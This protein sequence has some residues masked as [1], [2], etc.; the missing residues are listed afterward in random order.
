[1]PRLRVAP[2]PPIPPSCRIRTFLHPHNPFQSPLPAQFHTSTPF[3]KW[4]DPRERLHLRTI[5]RKERREERMKII[6]KRAKARL[7]KVPA[8]LKG[9]IPKEPET[10]KLERDMK[11]AELLRWNGRRSMYLGS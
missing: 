5:L 6:A 1:M 3:L 11:L 10:G 4:R 2:I 7:A 8:I 9:T